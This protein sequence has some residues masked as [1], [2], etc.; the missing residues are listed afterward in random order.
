LTSPRLVALIPARG[1]SQRVARKN[2]KPLA[3]KPLLVWTIYAAKA[4]GVFDAVFVSTEDEEIAAVAVDHDAD[5]L[6]RPPEYA[7]NFSPDIDWVMHAIRFFRR[8]GKDAFGAFAL[9]RPTSPFRRAET[10]QR[11]VAQWRERGADSDSLRAVQPVREHPGKMWELDGEHQT[12][13]PFHGFGLH[14]PPSHSRPTQSLPPVWVQNASLE[15]A[16]TKTVNEQRSI[17]G[18]RVMPFITEGHEGLDINSELDWL[19]A[20]TLITN[21]LARLPEAP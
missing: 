2:I 4:A 21:G 17:S 3:G 7:G 15:I 1:G 12:M 9:L 10:I 14:A 13:T 5:V 20:E 8:N 16:H 11:A 19:L 6:F 18:E